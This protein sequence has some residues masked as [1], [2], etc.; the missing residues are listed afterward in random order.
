MTLSH[1]FLQSTVARNLDANKNAPL[2][3]L[4]FTKWVKRQSG[5]LV[6]YTHL[7]REYVSR[8]GGVRR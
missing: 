4:L 1:N 6:R 2:N 7:L 8:G 3:F 5:K